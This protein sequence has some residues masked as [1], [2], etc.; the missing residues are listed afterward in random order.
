MVY[1]RLE[2]Q[3]RPPSLESLQA[4]PFFCPESLQVK[5]KDNLLD[6]I[7]IRFNSL[8]NLESSLNKSVKI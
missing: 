6:R 2:K 5:Q 1:L 4:I 7:F 8:I 3:G